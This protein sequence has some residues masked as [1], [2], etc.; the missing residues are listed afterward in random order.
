MNQPVKVMAAL[1]AFDDLESDLDSLGIS[2]YP[3]SV[4]LLEELKA[5]LHDL[6]TVPAVSW[7][8]KDCLFRCLRENT[9]DNAEA[10]DVLHPQSRPSVCEL[11]VP[12]GNGSVPVGGEV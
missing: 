7:I 1:K 6:Q 12:C 3:E 9:C 11:Y 8:C 5:R 10:V 4:A 2:E